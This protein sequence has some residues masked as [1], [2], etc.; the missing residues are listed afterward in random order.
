MFF[1]YGPPPP[2][3]PTTIY[4][5]IDHYLPTARANA[6]PEIINAIFDFGDHEL[7]ER[8]KEAAEAKESGNA[9]MNNKHVPYIPE[10]NG[11]SEFQN[12]EHTEEKTLET[13]EGMQTYIIKF[14]NDYL[15]QEQ[16]ETDEKTQDNSYGIV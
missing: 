1:G 14:N 9:H 11:F 7:A 4:H 16:T 5:R 6:A 13:D 12:K 3:P 15:N 2:P 10:G 8:R